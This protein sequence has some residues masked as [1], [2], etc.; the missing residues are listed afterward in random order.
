MQAVLLTYFLQ[1]L[2]LV[3]EFSLRSQQQGSRQQLL[4]ALVQPTRSQM[5]FAMVDLHLI[6][7]MDGFTS[8]TVQ[9]GNTLHLPHHQTHD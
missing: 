1:V 2:Q 5:L 7:R 9:H 8:T 3:P 6:I 4:M